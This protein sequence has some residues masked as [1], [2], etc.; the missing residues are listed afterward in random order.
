M[1][2]KIIVTNNQSMIE[3]VFPY[4]DAYLFGV[5]GYSTNMPIYYSLDELEP[6]IRDLH[7]QKKEVF[8]S[9]N[10]NMHSHD[11]DGLKELLKRLDHLPISGIFYYDVALVQLKKEGLFHLP[12]I[13][14]QE[15]LATNYDTC[16]FWKNIGVDMAC[17]SNEI[18]LEEIK[19]IRKNLDMPLIVPIFGYLPMFVSR[20][21]LVQNYT[22]KFALESKDRLHY[23]KKEGYCYPIIDDETGTEVYSSQILNGLSE[24][25]V[26]DQIGIDY[27]LFYSFQISNQDMKKVLQLFSKIND[28]NKNEVEG[29][30]NSL[31]PNLDKGFFYKETVFKVKKNEK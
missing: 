10:K 2:K 9:L 22:S 21:H 16:L 27:L 13:W 25:L 7:K 5:K 29:E 15:H 6:I 14:N 11:L 30:M 18:T 1:M 28:A 17:L 26:L 23:L 31:F 19:T 4:V 8:I 12:I 3:E 24:S 20:R